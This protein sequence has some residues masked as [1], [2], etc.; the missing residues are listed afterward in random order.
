LIRNGVDRATARRAFAPDLPPEISKRRNKGRIDQH[1]R[2]VLDA[3]LDFVRDRL[4]NGRLVEQ[5]LLNRRN[6]ELYLTRDRSPADFQY[7][8][9]LQEQLCVEAWLARWLDNREPLV[10]PQ[11]YAG[12]VSHQLLRT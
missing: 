6:L 3:N 5:G 11:P 10:A 12:P 9:I 8:E 4:L 2:D 7:S 1:L